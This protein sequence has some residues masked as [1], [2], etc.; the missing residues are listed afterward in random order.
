[1]NTKGKYG[2]L[3]KNFVV[4][5]IGAFSS[6]ILVF[7]LMPLYTRILTNS[8][9]GV[10]DLITSTANLL[11]P[12]ITLGIVQAVIRFGLDK[13][14]KKS[15]VFT[16]GILATV[17]GFIILLCFLPLIMTFDSVSAYTVLIYV[18]IFFSSI[19]Q[20]SSQFVRARGYVKLYTIDGCIST[21][22]TCLFTALYLAVFRWGINGYIAAIITA[23]VLSTIFLFVMADLKKYFKPK[24][25]NRSVVAGMIR[26]SIPMIPNTIFWWITTN[27]DRYMV[28]AYLGTGVNGLYAVANKMPSIIMVLSSIF[29]EAWQIS[30]MEDST[31]HERNKFFTTI[32]QSY[33]SIV[34]MIASGLIMTCQILIKILTGKDFHAAWEY[35]PFLM[36]ATAF[37]C[38]VS[39]L[40]SVYMVEKKSG[41][42][43]ITTFAGAVINI[44]LNFALIPYMGANGA[45]FATFA[46]YFVVLFVR[47]LTTRKF[48]KIDPNMPKLLASTAVLLIQSYVIIAQMPY[49][50]AIEIF[51]FCL[52]A[53]MNGGCVV[54]SIRKLLKK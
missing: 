25:L 30:A 15:D 40:S 48:I 51:L 37:S 4:F 17:G 47:L 16:T 28:T 45:A 12:F 31:P 2:R 8:E 42:S 44:V 41:Q 32:F 5:G 46:S 29:T 36:M 10:V 49:W 1:M 21:V 11:I 6:K 9:Y 34:F 14:I 27:S 54:R 22:T 39:F 18:F 53:V 50:I 38:L 3:I 20:L 33:Q 24:G 13:N 52:V 43:M 35:V 19:R 23:D 26:Y 7:L